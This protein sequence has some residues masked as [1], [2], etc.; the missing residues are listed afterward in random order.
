MKYIIIYVLIS[1][2]LRL[3]ISFTSYTL[4]DFKTSK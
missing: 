1:F 3:I 2:L 4:L